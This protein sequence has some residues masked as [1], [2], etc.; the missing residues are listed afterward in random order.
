MG[1]YVYEDGADDW[2]ELVTVAA[3]LPATV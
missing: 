2:T 1:T 3:R